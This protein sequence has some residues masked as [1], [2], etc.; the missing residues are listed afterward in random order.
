MSDA[1]QD[2]YEA[3]FLDPTTPVAVQR[4]ER[5]A[6]MSREELDRLPVGAIRLDRDGT[7]LEY[8]AAEARLAQRDPADVIGRNFFTEVAPCTNVQ[9]FAGRFREDV[10]S[11]RPTVAFP[12]VFRFPERDVTVM[13]LLHFEPDSDSGSPGVVPDGSTEGDG[14]RIPRKP[15]QRRHN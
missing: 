3:P 8:N 14:G 7:I 6:S 13:V 12:Y 4:I 11:D 10:G 9:E 1:P 5:M 2:E 15:A